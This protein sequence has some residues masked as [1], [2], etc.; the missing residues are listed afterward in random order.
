MEQ[1]GVLC[2]KRLPLYEGWP[3]VGFIAMMDWLHATGIWPKMVKV[4]PLG[5]EVEVHYEEIFS[6]SCISMA[7]IC[8]AA[9]HL[10]GSQTSPFLGI[11][12]TEEVA[13]SM[14]GW[15][16]DKESSREFDHSNL[17]KK[18]FS[19]LKPQWTLEIQLFEIEAYP[20]EQEMALIAEHF[21]LQVG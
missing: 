21:E 3:Q 19:A 12:T 9:Q 17:H 20:G 14:K 5:F 15:L 2:R 1:K 18:Q 16:K 11:F 4:V 6:N 8:K 13:N 7:R 10:L